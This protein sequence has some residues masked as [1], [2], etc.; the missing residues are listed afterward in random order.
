MIKILWLISALLFSIVLWV[1]S[2]RGIGLTPDSVAYLKAVQGMIN[3]HGFSYFSVQWPPLYPSMLYLV[4]LLTGNDFFASPRLLNA[5]L[6][7][8]AFLLTGVLLTKLMM[9]KKNWVISYVFAGLICLHPVITHI[10]F[11]VLSE[12]LFIPL[13]LINLIVLIN[14][15]EKINELTLKQ[16]I[17]LS[18]LG[19]ALISTRYAGVTLIALNVFFIVFSAK[20]PSFRKKIFFT[21]IQI[22]SAIVILK[23]WLGHVGASDTETNQR[24]LVWHPVTEANMYDGLA[25]IGSWILPVIHPNESP[26]I[27]ISCLLLGSVAVIFF[28]L[29]T[30]KSFFSI[31]KLRQNNSI[32]P[33]V[34]VVWII[35]IFCMGYILFLI[36]VRSFIDPHIVFDSRFLSPIFIPIM[37]LPIYC[38][39]KISDRR[40]FMGG[41]VL[42]AL[43][44]AMPVKQLR[45]WLLI[46]YFNGIELNDKTRVNS[47]ILQFV[48]ECSK[49]ASVYAD[50]PWNFNLEFKSMVQWLPTYNFFGTGLPDPNYQT[51]LET[52]SNDVDIVIVENIQSDVVIVMNKNT[53]FRQ[54]YNQSDGIVWCRVHSTENCK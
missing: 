24:P 12:A 28:I 47:K 37:T 15:Y 54:I 21:S 23:N 38:A 50:N 5:F 20:V 48:R 33:T 44:Y 9:H 17:F 2:P 35:S 30:I 1:A 34:G 22:F 31:Y 6:Y 45:S 41:M 49:N 46:S 25:N 4:S 7:G 36:L 40:V 18:L 11:Y 13:V 52:F 3:G 32:T 43:I 29:I 8:T 39:T 51:K 16:S 42:I 27:R 10:Y 53:D 19:S 14:Y 26:L